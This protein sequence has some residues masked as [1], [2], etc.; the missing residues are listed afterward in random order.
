MNTIL[1]VISDDDAV[2]DELDYAELAEWE[3]W[4]R[5][6]PGVT[7]FGDAP[8]L[9]AV[10]NGRTVYLSADDMTDDELRAIAEWSAA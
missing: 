9:P 4:A 7:R 6:D 5:E 2:D 10:R 1:A 3:L 8:I